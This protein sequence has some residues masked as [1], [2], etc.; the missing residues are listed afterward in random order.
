VEGF[1]VEEGADLEQWLVVVG[2]GPPVDE[3]R[4][5]RGIVEPQDQAQRGGLAGAVGAEEAGD[6]ASVDLEAEMIHRNGF[7][8]PLREVP[9]LD[10]R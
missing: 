1:G 3:R 4:T 7:A 9:H 10:A 5:R 8:V 6:P 2:E